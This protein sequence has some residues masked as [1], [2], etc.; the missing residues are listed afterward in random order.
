[1]PSVDLSFPVFGEG[2]PK[3]HG[4][5][6]Y[7]AIS[8]IIPELH[9]AEWLG[10]FLLNGTRLDDG[11]IHFDKKSQL[12]L[13]LPVECIGDV[14]PLAGKRL[15]IAGGHLRTGTPSVHVL[16][17][18]DVLFARL[19][20]IR[21]TD[22]PYH[23]DEEL[24][25]STFISEE[26]ENRYKV[27][28]QRQLKEAGIECPFKMSGRRGVRVAEKQLVGFSVTITGLSREQSITL[29][30]KGIGGKRRMGCGLFRSPRADHAVRSVQ[31]RA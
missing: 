3:E 14:L 12:R 25:R 30:E 20:Y 19:V 5:A 29:Q 4:Y 16:T 26:F 24:G 9:G 27:E 15:N 23:L 11:H 18:S 10:I 6:L 1:M 28:I 13:R 21:L 8:G 31:D 17:P 22:V 2:V 7:S